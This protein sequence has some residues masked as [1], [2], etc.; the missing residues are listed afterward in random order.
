[1]LCFSQPV[2]AGLD[3][4]KDRPRLSAWRDRVKQELGVAVFHEAHEVIMN[5]AS[6][7]QTIENKGMLEF[8][9]PRLQKLFN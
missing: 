5:A 3:V 6:L 1:M 2:G 9:K 8:L 7:P 4:F